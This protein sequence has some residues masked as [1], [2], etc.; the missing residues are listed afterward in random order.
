ME[1]Q[2]KE[3]DIVF[4]RFGNLS[5]WTVAK[6]VYASQVGTHYVKSFDEKDP[7]IC[8]DREYEVREI[9]TFDISHFIK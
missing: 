9:L 7:T 4:V 6:Y 8:S 5:E 1:K 3:G 2:F